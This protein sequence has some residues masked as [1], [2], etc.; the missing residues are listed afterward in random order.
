MDSDSLPEPKKLLRKNTSVTTPGLPKEQYATKLREML[1]LDDI[2]EL[3]LTELT[4]SD[5][6]HIYGSQMTK[7]AL[8][9]QFNRQQTRFGDLYDQ[10]RIVGAG[11]FGIVVAC[12]DKATER[13]VALKL[14]SYDRKSP[15]QAALSILRECNIIE[16]MDHPNIIKLYDKHLKYEDFIVMEM[17][18]GEESLTSF[19]KS[20]REKHGNPLPEEQCAQIMKGV[21]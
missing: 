4:G 1:G 19:A 6:D 9:K 10:I 15:S 5:Q 21:L 11:S 12:L 17:E 20:Y 13:R 16:A 7:E 3:Q 2:G 8:D 18:L 14:A